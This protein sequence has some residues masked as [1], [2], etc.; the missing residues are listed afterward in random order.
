MWLL[1]DIVVVV[2]LLI[3][4]L[5]SV[6][7][8]VGIGFNIQQIR[9]NIAFWGLTWFECLAV[10]LTLA[11]WVVVVKLIFR[12]RRF[13]KAKPLL[14][15]HLLSF[16]IAGWRINEDIY[17][18]Q[19][20]YANIAVSNTGGFLDNC[21]GNV[22]SI[23]MVD[24]AKGQV[25]I[26]PMATFTPTSLC[27]DNGKTSIGIPNDG[28]PRML[29]LAYLDQNHSGKWQLAI[30][31]TKRQDYGTGWWKIDVV[32][33]SES[34]HANKLY[35][36]IALGLGDR[37]TPPSGLNL[38]PWDKWYEAMTKELKQESHKEDYQT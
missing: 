25:Y 29:N 24:I 4:A 22:K 23:S 18:P 15:A 31:G 27:W 17:T 35:V 33:S 26:R 16:P 28:V 14:S 2:G 10:V 1:K 21:I 32:I 20:G 8:G 12:L 7:G 5:L 6:I 13:E 19:K 30:E 34:E 37:E 36:E 3:M 9:E 38:W 11:F